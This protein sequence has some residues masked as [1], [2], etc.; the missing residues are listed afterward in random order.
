[1]TNNRYRRPASP[2]GAAG[3]LAL[4]GLVLTI[5]CPGT[6]ADDTSRVRVLT[7]NI[8]HGEGMDGKIDLPRI[9]DAIKRLEPDVVALQE[10]DVRTT[11]SHG[12]D[13]S[14]ELGRLTGMHSAFGKAMDFAGGEYGEAILSRWPLADVQVFDLPTTTGCEP[15]CVITA[16]IER[17]NGGPPFLFAGTHLEHAQATLRLCQAGKLSPALAYV[18]PLPAIL[19]G[20][21]NAEPGSPPLS[22]LRQHWTTATAQQTLPTFPADQPRLML[23]HVLYRPDARWRVLEARVVEEPLASDHRPLLVVL[24]MQP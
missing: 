23:D 18:K 12:V 2:Y 11:R 1:M 22:V 7:Y 15:R 20:D 9:A 19:A 6:S 5:V 3:C 24:E 4:I 8:H 10:V 16:R 17:S 21:L 14:A 13:Q